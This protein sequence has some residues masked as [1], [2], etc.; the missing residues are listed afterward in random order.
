MI[1]MTTSTLQTEHID[2]SNSGGNQ[3]NQDSRA[4][5][6]CNGFI[7]DEPD[8][9]GTYAHE[10]SSQDESYYPLGKAIVALIENL[11]GTEC[12]GVSRSG[13]SAANYSG[14]KLSNGWSLVVAHDALALLPP[15]G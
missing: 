7:F 2:P 12:T 4:E 9:I 8:V 3:V 14:M 11:G 15:Q 13:N 6:V 10:R 1:A 5:G